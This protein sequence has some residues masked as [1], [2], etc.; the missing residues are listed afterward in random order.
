MFFNT[1]SPHEH[2]GHALLLTCLLLRCQYGGKQ[3]TVLVGCT[4]Q[5]LSS[6]GMHKLQLDRP[7][8]QPMA[9][10]LT[11]G[12]I[13]L[14]AGACRSTCAAGGLMRRCAAATDCLSLTLAGSRP[15]ACDAAARCGV[16][17]L[18]ACLGCDTLRMSRSNFLGFRLE[19]RQGL[20]RE[21]HQEPVK[22]LRP[23][24]KGCVGASPLGGGS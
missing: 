7:Q 8:T 24:Y 13:R 10:T 14:A 5:Q 3:T 18:A 23:S 4:R 1:T 19:S 20:S 12:H 11:A 17:V 21:G 6:V 22:I 16:C 15:A 9:L 2:P